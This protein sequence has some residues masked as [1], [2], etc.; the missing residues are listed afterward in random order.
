MKEI[1]W[2]L[3]NVLLVLTFVTKQHFNKKYTGYKK[4]IRYT[5]RGRGGIPLEEAGLFVSAYQ[6]RDDNFL[7]AA[8]QQELQQCLHWFE[9]HV[10]LACLDELSGLD[11]QARCWYKNPRREAC[12]FDHKVRSASGDQ[13]APIDAVVPAEDLEAESSIFS[14]ATIHQALSQT[15]K[16][17]EMM[18]R[19]GFVVH[20]EQTDRPGVILHQHEV[21]ITAIPVRNAWHSL[22]LQ[23]RIWWQRHIP[24]VGF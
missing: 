14:E 7:T 23:L 20:V 3:A 15:E 9:R 12:V 18:R 24:T 22:R 2:A 5:T 8:E 17:A 13:T 16:L 10:R 6:L 1:P 4:Y 11:Q 19:H 21:Q